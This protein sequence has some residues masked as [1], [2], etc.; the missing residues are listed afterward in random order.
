M[1]VPF[2]GDTLEYMRSPVAWTQQHYERHGPV[3]VLPMFGV[4][5]MAVVLGPDAIEEVL[6]NRDRAFSSAE[7]W[8][9]FVGPF[10]HRGLLLLDGDEHRLHRRIMQQ[11][12]LPARISAYLDR[13]NPAI[14]RDLAS[15]PADGTF[16]IAPAIQ[17]M[18][19]TMTSE[20]LTGSGLGAAADEVHRMFEACLQAS[21]S[22]LRVAV[23]GLPWARGIAARRRLEEIFGAWVE[24]RRAS[25][26]PADNLLSMLCAAVTE[27]GEQFTAQDVVNHMILLLLAARDTSA[28]ALTSIIYHLAGHPE[29]QQRCREDGSALELVR[30]ESLRLMPPLGQLARRAVRPTTVL[31][32]PLAAGTYVMPILQFSH[33]MPGVWSQPSVFDPLRFAPDRAE[34]KAH[35]YAWTP[36]GGGVHHCIGMHFATAVVNAVMAQLLERYEWSVE[37]GYEVPWNRRGVPTPADGLPVRL[38]GRDRTHGIAP[39]H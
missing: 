33:H 2:L 37:P 26:G 18:I 38:R 8:S 27:D 7:G 36:F 10:F 1:K 15:W 39:T 14:T 35:R 12:F 31:G 34:D 5:K 4:R 29:W 21:Y 20:V 17:S 11:A 25:G 23:P 13:M 22:P 19:F 30:K 28:S 3:S 24:E 6:L 16:E 9:K 32:H